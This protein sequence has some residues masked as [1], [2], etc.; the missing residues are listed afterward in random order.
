ME[1]DGG[2]GSCTA[3]TC[4]GTH[5][6]HRDETEKK[7]TRLAHGRPPEVRWLLRPVELER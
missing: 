6:T 3:T 2:R 5:G 4:G 7:S 1:I